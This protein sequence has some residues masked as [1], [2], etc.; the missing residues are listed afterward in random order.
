VTDMGGVSHSSANA[1]RGPAIEKSV[2]PVLL[3]S[4]HGTSD[5]HTDRH[6]RTRG[7]SAADPHHPWHSQRPRDRELLPHPG[8]TGF[9]RS[10]R[11]GHRPARL[12]SGSAT[13]AGR[14]H[15]RARPAETAGPAFTGARDRHRATITAQVENL[16]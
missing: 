5:T 10:H 6:P 9:T 7:D 11:E 12:V 13:Q 14:L 2:R 8:R 15:P 3:A 1:P 16:L 4:R